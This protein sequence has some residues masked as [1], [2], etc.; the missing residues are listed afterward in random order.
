ML[1]GV[2]DAVCVFEACGLLFVVF[3]VQEVAVSWGSLQIVDYP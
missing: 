3:A 2:G 1:M